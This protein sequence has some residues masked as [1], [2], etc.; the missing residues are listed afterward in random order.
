MGAPPHRPARA[1]LSG[2]RGPRGREEWPVH[3]GLPVD[4]EPWPRYLGH[5]SS[6]LSKP[7]QGSGDRSEPEVETWP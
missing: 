2:L 1:V 5:S 6:W 4:T 3:P 7:V